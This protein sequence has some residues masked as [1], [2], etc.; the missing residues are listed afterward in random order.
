MSLLASQKWTGRQVNFTT[1]FL[2]G[3]LSEPVFMSQPP[4]FEDPQHPDWVCQ[5]KRSIYG[6]KQ[7]PREWN[8]KLHSALVSIGLCQSKYDPTLYFRLDGLRLMGALA[9]HV[10]DL[11]VVG[12]D[13]FVNS[14]IKA[15]GQHFRIGADELLHHFLSL[16]IDRSSEERLVYLSQDHYISKMSGCFLTNPSPPT[17]TPTDSAFKDLARRQPSKPESLGPH[18]QLVGCSMYSPRY[19]L[20]G[21]PPVSISQGSIQIPLE[22]CLPCS[23]VLGY[24][25]ASL[26]LTGRL[27]RDVWFL[28]LRLGGGP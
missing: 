1:A 28:G 20:C 17:F 4:G 27:P 12:E 11:A 26:A 16:K 9:I 13:S 14:T 2:N 3:H 10:N 24:H 6:L 19:L 18:Q 22:S 15:L 8:L 25:K 21:Q 5:V 23:P 7:L